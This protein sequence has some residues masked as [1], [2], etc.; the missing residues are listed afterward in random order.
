M[1]PIRLADVIQ[2]ADVGVVQSR[3]GLRF[4]LE[5]GAAIRVGAELGR[6]HLDGDAAVEAGVAGLEDPAHST[7]ADDRLKFVGAE[8]GAGTQCHGCTSDWG[9]FRR[10]A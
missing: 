3:Y 5:A 6:Q 7:L 2:G 4:A 10:P 1:L 9:F 8:A